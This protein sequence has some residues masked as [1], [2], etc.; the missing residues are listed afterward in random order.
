MDTYPRR[1][2]GVQ[3]FQCGV[4]SLGVG[5]PRSGLVCQLDPHNGAAGE[6]RPSALAARKLS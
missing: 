6:V 4:G 5:M 1:A 3:G 2:G